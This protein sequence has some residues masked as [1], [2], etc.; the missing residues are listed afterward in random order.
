[1]IAKLRG[2]KGQYKKQIKWNCAKKE[3]R[4]NL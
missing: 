4:E 2:L 1:M 3:N